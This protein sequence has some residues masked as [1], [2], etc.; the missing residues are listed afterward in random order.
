METSG[1]ASDSAGTKGC[2]WDIRCGRV[3]AVGTFC[4]VHVKMSRHT[5]D[6]AGGPGTYEPEEFT[7]RFPDKPV[8]DAHWSDVWTDSFKT[9]IDE[10]LGEP[11]ETTLA[12]DLSLG[13]EVLRLAQICG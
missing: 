4:Q 7:L 1:T 2:V 11:K 8:L 6:P 12:A 13:V 10:L 5:A 3:A 9:V